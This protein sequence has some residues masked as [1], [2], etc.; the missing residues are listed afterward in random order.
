VALRPWRRAGTGRILSDLATLESEIARALPHSP[1]SRPPEPGHVYDVVIAGGGQSGLS[2]AWALQRDGIDNILVTDASGPGLEGPWATFARMPTLRTPKGP[3]GVEAGL[4]G[5]TVRDWYEAA[6]GAD[7]WDRIALIPTGCWMEYLRW[8][9]RITGVNFHNHMTLLSILSG[10]PRAPLR[11]EYNGPEGPLTLYARKLVL[12][13]GYAGAGGEYIPEEFAAALP[14][15]RFAHTSEMVDFEGLRGKAVGVIG[16]G[17]SAFDNAATAAESGARVVHQFVRR[18]ELPVVNLVRWMDFSAFARH[19][20]DLPDPLR[21]A[22]VRSFIGTPMPPPPETITR[23]KV[24]TNHRLHLDAPILGLP[25]EDEGIIVA[26]KQGR[27]VVDFLIVGTGFEVDLARRPELAAS[28]P[29]IA[30]WGDRYNPPQRIDWVDD[31]IARYPYLGADLQFLEQRPGTAPHLAAVHVF[32]AAV[33]ASAGPIG[34]GINGL[35]FNASRLA[36][37]LV[38]DLWLERRMPAEPAA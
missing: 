28:L 1:Q 3:T 38:R 36:G 24:L 14:R 21:Y 11:L 20:R 17:A 34:S 10:G 25:E 16:A 9:R 26:T 18:A 19:F 7:A 15:A 32:N 33:V 12:A 5:M 37:A 6:F 13:T 22:Y 31:K 4:A 27:Q 35:K 30:L 29:H 8:M 2:V 23:V